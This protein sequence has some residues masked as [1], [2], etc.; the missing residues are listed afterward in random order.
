MPAVET[1]V[2]RCTA[3]VRR[4]TWRA[5]DL[6]LKL[7]RMSS[8][9]SKQMNLRIHAWWVFFLF[10]VL[11]RD[12]HDLFVPGLVGQMNEG[13]LNGE[14]VTASIILA[15]GIGI[16]IPIL[17]S[18][19]ALLVG[20]TVGRPLHMAVA[21]LLVPAMFLAEFRDLDDY[22][23][24]M[25]ESVALVGVAWTAWSWSEDGKRPFISS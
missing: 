16:E 21:V 14:P 9:S 23:F 13:V 10:N 18:L 5:Y 3:R 24:F 7:V 11:F 4:Q 1:R 22:F 17:M 2:R 12:L 20:R 15:G 6:R 19:L 8:S 25:V